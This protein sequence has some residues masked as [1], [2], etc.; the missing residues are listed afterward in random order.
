MTNRDFHDPRARSNEPALGAHRRR[1]SLEIVDIMN[2]ESASGGG[3]GA[4]RSRFARA[5][6]LIVAAFRPVSARLRRRRHVRPSGRPRCHRMPAT[7]G[8]PPTMVTGWIAALSRAREE[9]RGREDDVNAGWRPM[10]TAEVTN[11]DVVVESRRAVRRRM[12]VPHWARHRRSAPQ[13]S[14]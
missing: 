2:A 5:I 13:P 3:A 1:S 6:D 12:C 14:C 9:R 4:R 7:F 8:V 10:D 11:R